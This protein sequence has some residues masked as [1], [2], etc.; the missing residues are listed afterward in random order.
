VQSGFDKHTSKR[1]MDAKTLKNTSTNLKTKRHDA[2]QKKKSNKDEHLPNVM[3]LDAINGK[4]VFYKFDGGDNRDDKF[5]FVGNLIS[6][7]DSK[8]YLI[9]K[10]FMKEELKEKGYK[11]YL[12]KEGPVKRLTMNLVINPFCSEQDM[13]MYTRMGGAYGNMVLLKL[14]GFD[15]DEL[16]QICIAQDTHEKVNVEHTDSWSKLMEAA[17]T[18]WHKPQDTS[19][20]FSTKRRGITMKDP[21]DD[22]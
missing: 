13:V 3:L 1:E 18:I 6:T 15:F 17:I 8:C 20:T 12:D 14:D 4:F 9:E 11:M 21:E 19:I 16:K 5:V 2:I 10:A 22:D 7:P